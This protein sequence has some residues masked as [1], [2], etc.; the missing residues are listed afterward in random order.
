MVPDD[1]PKEPTCRCEIVG[2]VHQTD[3]EYV[4]P[5]YVFP[6]AGSDMASIVAVPAVGTHGM[7]AWMDDDSKK[8]WLVSDLVKRIPNARVLFFDHGKPR[9]QDDLGSLGKSLLDQVHKERQPAV[10]YLLHFIQSHILTSLP[11]PKTANS[12]YLP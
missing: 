6:F 9:D 8:P 12:F 4:S 2:S 3:V 7:T 1:V 5:A 10:C 11:E